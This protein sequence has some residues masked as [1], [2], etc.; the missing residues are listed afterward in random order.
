MLLS[1]LQGLRKAEPVLN[2]ILVQEGV[3]SMKPRKR[4]Q[5][6]EISYRCPGYDKPFY[7][8]FSTLEEANIRCAEIQLSQARGDLRPPQKTTKNKYI[9]VGD[10]M[11]EYVEL[12]GLNHWSD[13]YLSCSR[14]RIKHYIKPY[15]G[16]ML[17]Q[18]LTSHDLDAFYNNLLKQ[19][20]VVLKGHTDTCKKVSTAVIK[21]VHDLLRSALN[22]AVAWEYIPANP[23][24][25]ATLPRH[26]P[27]TRE[28]WT[29][30]EAICAL[31]LC[32]DAV[33]KLAMLL[34]IGCSMRIGEI[35][36][37]TWDCV[38]ISPESVQQ[39]NASV[40]INKEIKR[41]DKSSIADLAGHGHSD[42][43]FTFP[44][45]K[46]GEAKTSLALKGPK[47][48]SSIRHVFLP[49]TVIDALLAAREEQDK[50]KAF[51]ADAYQDFNLVFAHD[52]GR[53][54]EERQIAQK[55]KA[56]IKEAGLP[57]VVFHSLRHCSTSIKLAISHGNIKAVRGD[58]GHAQARMV[59]D[60]YAHTSEG[61]R[62]N[63]AKKMEEDFFKKCASQQGD[64]STSIDPS[65]AQA[66]KLLQ[67]DPQLAQLLLAV[68]QSHKLK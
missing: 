23:A 29:E 40:F 27:K 66:T 47:T 35:L 51:V 16:D 34:A 55:L 33:L 15:L 21:K 4:G 50:M 39:N 9:T 45:W 18:H 67:D 53:P 3:H 11:D 61:P 30:E 42:I 26:R 62:R 17:L 13:S 37:L 19:P 68:V 5:Q 12:Y 58:T 43:I 41:C 52:T 38:D 44:E 20:A 48:E 46:Q 56:F 36:G 8:R 32:G 22:Q 25:K 1:L 7:E 10:L 28:V 65:I 14:H 24:E 64:A 63:L 59:T 60:V 2:V 31:N 57:P 49:Q 54:Y 6:Y